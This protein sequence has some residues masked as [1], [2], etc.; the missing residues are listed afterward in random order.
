MSIK[1][2]IT[3]I[4]GE[5][6]DGVELVAVSKTHPAEAVVAAYNAGMRVFGENKAQEMR[7]KHEVLPED[8]EWHMIGHMQ[9]NKV[10]YIAPFVAM[11]QSVD[12]VRLLDVI[13]KEA[14]KNGRV[15]D[16]L[17]EV[18]IAQEESKSGWETEELLEY[19]RSG[20]HLA[21]PNIRI[22]GLMGMASF[23][24]DEQQV[25]AEFTVLRELHDRVRGEFFADDPAFDTLSMGM[26]SDWRIAVE[27]GSTMVR[28]GSA[29]FGARDYGTEE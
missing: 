25:R 22:R 4:R 20:A 7:A 6:P 19:L 10:K 11:I 15:I 8:I 24:D 14:A 28:I 17:M 27:C 12:S 3:S 2:Q 26:T 13:D 1:E 9:T 18:Y 16:V 5:L 29:I 21:K 23:T